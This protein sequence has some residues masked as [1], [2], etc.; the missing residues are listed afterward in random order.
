MTRKI[1]S[2]AKMYALGSISAS[3]VLE[4]VAEEFPELSTEFNKEVVEAFIYAE[5]YGKEYDSYC[6]AIAQG[7]GMD[8]QTAIEY[9][10]L[11]KNIIPQNII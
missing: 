11:H 6:Q 8:E 5:E 4:F 10:Q 2:A 7:M 9:S 3:Q 1:Q